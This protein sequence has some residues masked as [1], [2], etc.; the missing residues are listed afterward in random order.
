MKHFAIALASITTTPDYNNVSRL[1]SHLFF[2]FLVFGYPNIAPV[3][4]YVF[5]LCVDLAG[6]VEEHLSDELGH[7]YSL[8]N[9]LSVAGH[10]GKA[11][12]VKVLD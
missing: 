5:D 11:L 3:I 6:H 8:H 4:F 2:P 1:H 12:L 7:G 10:L 9:L